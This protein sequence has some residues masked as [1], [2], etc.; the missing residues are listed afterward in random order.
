MTF[1]KVICNIR[2]L[3]QKVQNYRKTYK[4]RKS[5]NSLRELDLHFRAAPVE[6]PSVTFPPTILH[7]Y[8]H[9]NVSFHYIFV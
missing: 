7:R 9:R 6:C 3:M 4:A 8:C 2:L 5:V 1:K